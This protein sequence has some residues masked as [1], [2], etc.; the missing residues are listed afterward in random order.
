MSGKKKPERE[1]HKRDP[2]LPRLVYL[3]DTLPNKWM[4]V[5]TWSRSRCCRRQLRNLISY[6]PHCNPGCCSTAALLTH[7]RYLTIDIKEE[8]VVNQ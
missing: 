6:P 1:L 3:E 5:N 8:L 4:N 2:S 7:S